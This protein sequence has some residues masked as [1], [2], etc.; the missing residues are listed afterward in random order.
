M[1][2]AIMGV[3]GDVSYCQPPKYPSKLL[4]RTLM[5]FYLTMGTDNVLNK[6]IINLDEGASAPKAPP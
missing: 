3:T 4:H 5:S 6:I 1:L 2:Q